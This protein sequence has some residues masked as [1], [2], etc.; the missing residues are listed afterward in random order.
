MGLFD[1][2]KENQYGHKLIK[3]TSKQMK[4]LEKETEKVLSSVD[5]TP[6]EFSGHQRKY[7][8]KDVSPWIIWQYSGQ[9]GKDC[10]GAGIRKGDSLNLIEQPT[11]EDSDCV[12]IFWKKK[13]IGYMKNSRLRHMVKLWNHNGLPVIARVSHI[14]GEHN[15]M[16]EIA[17]YGS[18]AKPKK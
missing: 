16:Y 8:Y 17:F 11:K 12:A 4:Q 5:L 7:H 18:P 15:L 13:H 6:G 9:Y 2:L 1:S 14:G 10:K 3:E